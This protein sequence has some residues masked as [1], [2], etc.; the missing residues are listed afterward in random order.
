MPFYTYILQSIASGHKYYGSCE[1]V[2]I[3]LARHNAEKVKSSKRYAPYN[4]FIQK[5]ILHEV[6]LSSG[7]SFLNLF[8]GIII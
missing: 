2:E 1:D 7:K 8:K 3:R 6:K 4:I 5:N